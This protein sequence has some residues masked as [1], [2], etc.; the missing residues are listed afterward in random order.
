VNYLNT[1]NCKIL[2]EDIKKDTNKWKDIPRSWVVNIVEMSIL[3]K[4]STVSAIPFNLSIS[5][6]TDT[7]T[8]KSQNLHVITKD[9]K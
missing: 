4:Q 3:P 1:E 9:G 5:F 2:V 8:I 7:K 6:F